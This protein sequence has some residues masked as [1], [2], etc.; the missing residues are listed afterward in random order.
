MTEHAYDPNDMAS[1]KAEARKRSR[2]VD[3]PSYCQALDAIAREGGHPH[4]KAMLKT[5]SAMHPEE[6]GADAMPRSVGI[7]AARSSSRRL[8]RWIS[9][10]MRD[11]GAWPR[12]ALRRIIEDDALV[13]D[14][15]SEL[16]MTFITTPA[17]SRPSI[18]DAAALIVAG[19]AHDSIHRSNPDILESMLGTGPASPDAIVRAVEGMHNAAPPMTL[20]GNFDEAAWERRQSLSTSNWF[21]A[22]AAHAESAGRP[23]MAELLKGLSCG[24]HA[25][26]I[27][28]L[29]AIRPIRLLLEPERARFERMVAERYAARTGND[30][31]DHDEDARATVDAHLEDEKVGFDDPGRDW[32]RDLAN[33]LADEDMQYWE[34]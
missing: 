2:I 9:D 27:A 20:A 6:L 17:L 21:A 3:G 7:E 30:A 15:R 10:A 28:V 29:S 22:M 11:A 4:W 25:D 26:R 19:I 32:S 33:E 5:G 24:D 18:R 1:M 14:E 12:K 16:A 13:F 34:P 8:N 23:G 31:D